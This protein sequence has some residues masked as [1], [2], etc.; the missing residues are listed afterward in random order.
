MSVHL[1]RHSA[2]VHDMAHGDRPDVQRLL[3]GDA[4]ARAAGE[5]VQALSTRADCAS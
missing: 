4:Y 2:I 3:V 5:S 1:N